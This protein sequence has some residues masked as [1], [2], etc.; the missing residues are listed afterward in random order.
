MCIHKGSINCLQ[1]DH[2]C[3]HRILDC[4]INLP[5]GLIFR[6]AILVWCRVGR[7]LTSQASM[8]TFMTESTPSNGVPAA[9]FSDRPTSHTRPFQTK[10]KFT[11]SSVLITYRFFSSALAWCSTYMVWPCSSTVE[12]YRYSCMVIWS[13]ID[14]ESRIEIL[15]GLCGMQRVCDVGETGTRVSEPLQYYQ[16]K[17]V[18]NAM[19]ISFT[20][21]QWMQMNIRLLCWC[22][23]QILTATLHRRVAVN[24]LH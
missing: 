2:K 19:L 13:A 3:H 1:A 14:C 22:G 17:R 20:N 10:T 24:G 8:I 11:H 16:S 15:G 5:H 7:Q 6:L 4:L 9:A 12:G 18:I 21:R 23:N